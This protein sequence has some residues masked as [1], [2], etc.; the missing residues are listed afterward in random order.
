MDQVEIVK[1]LQHAVVLLKD[2]GLE[3]TL[4][5]ILTLRRGVIEAVNLQA[6]GPSVTVP[7][8]EAVAGLLHDYYGMDWSLI[9]WPV[10]RRE[11]PRPYPMIG[12]YSPLVSSDEHN[13]DV[14]E[15]FK[16]YMRRRQAELYFP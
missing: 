11:L 3:S 8:L 14:D 5:E 2:C 10:K 9:W 12:R 7:S 16:D 6:Q 15:V 13:M 1:E 4:S